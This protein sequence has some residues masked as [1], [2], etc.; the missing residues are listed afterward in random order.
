MDH[1]GL[2]EAVGMPEAFGSFYTGSSWFSVVTHQMKYITHYNKMVDQLWDKHS[3][4][5]MWQWSSPGRGL[6]PIEVR[7]PIEVWILNEVQPYLEW[8]TDSCVQHFIYFPGNR[9]D[10]FFAKL[11]T[12]LWY[13]H[14]LM[15]YFKNT[16]VHWGQASTFLCFNKILT[17]Q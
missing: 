15:C 17:G 13:F 16:L 3:Q 14:M 1:T 4:H 9:R 2:G 7:M 8:G 10:S 11:V 5:L 12:T 6:G